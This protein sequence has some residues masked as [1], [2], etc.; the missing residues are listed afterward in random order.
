MTCAQQ[1]TIPA[2]SMAMVSV[3]PRNLPTTTLDC[4]N[5]YVACDPSHKVFANK[6]I[7]LGHSLLC[8]NDK[9]QLLLPVTNFSGSDQWINAGTVLG[10][11]C[12]ITGVEQ[13]DDFV[14]HLE[15]QVEF[16]FPVNDNLPERD[17]KRV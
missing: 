2:F 17:R 7:F 12:E 13:T 9:D 1:Q 6:G 4:L 11:I 14:S 10:T 8:L 5:W 3:K 16:D 15:S